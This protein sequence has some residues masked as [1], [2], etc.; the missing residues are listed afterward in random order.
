MLFPTATF[1]IFFLVVLPL[2]WLLMPHG[3][4][5][6][7]VHHRRKL[8]LLRR[9]G[10]ALLLPAR[11]LD[12]VEPG[13]R[14]RDPRA[15]RRTRA[16]VAPRRGADWKPRPPRLLQVLRLLRHVDQ[17][18]LCVRRDRRPGRDALDHPPGRDL[19]LHVH[20]D[21]L[22]RRR[23]P[24]RLRPG[25][26]GEVRGLSL[27]LSPPGRRAHR[28]AGRADPPVRSA[29]RPALRGH[30]ARV[31]PDRHR[32]L[33][34]SRDRQL[35]GVEHRGPGLRSAEPALLARGTRRDLR[36]CRPD[37]RRLLRVHEHCD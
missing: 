9:L 33:H 2:S 28:P 19:L 32:A 5:W 6:R 24:R 21:Q 30:L 12:P 25:R 29:P 35:P 4:R 7:A 22:R 15:A 8:R 23:L 27:L 18:R 14:A 26:S 17:Q 11:V 1:A 3:E 13:L 37:L 36:L 20:G 34:E 31:L 10:L 16:E